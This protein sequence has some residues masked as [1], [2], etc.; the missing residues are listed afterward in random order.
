[1]LL[2]IHVQN[3]GNLKNEWN[4][5]QSLNNQERYSYHMIICVTCR[6]NGTWCRC[7]NI[8]RLANIISSHVIRATVLDVQEPVHEDEVEFSTTSDA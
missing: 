7:T 8:S 3:E 6:R 2:K 4:L 5:K 1:M